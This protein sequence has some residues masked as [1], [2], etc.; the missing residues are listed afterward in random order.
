MTILQDKYKLV[1]DEYHTNGFNR[2]LAYE[3]YF[4]AR[5]VVASRGFYKMMTK[6]F[7]AAY[8]TKT[9]K[10]M[11]NM[12]GVNKESVVLHLMKDLEGYADFLELANREELTELEERKFKRLSEVYSQSGKVQTIN[13][14]AKILGL[15]EPEKIQ[16]EEVK[17]VVNFGSKKDL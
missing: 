6:P 15:F 14:I 11:A 12:M 9:Q 1:I 16:V 8:Y 2:K 4:E 3:K 13:T 7:A 17:Y 10:E 5:G